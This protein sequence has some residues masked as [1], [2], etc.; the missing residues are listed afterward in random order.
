MTKWIIKNKDPILVTVIFGIF[1]EISRYLF[2][3]F[4]DFFSGI[5]ISFIDKI[6][7]LF[8]RTVSSYS[9]LAYSYSVVQFFAL[10]LLSLSIG[11]CLGPILAR[12]KDS[13]RLAK[14]MSQEEFVANIKS[15]IRKMKVVII[16]SSTVVFLFVHFFLVIPGMYYSKFDRAMTIV[17]PYVEDVEYNSLK[18][19]WFLMK[20]KAD[21]DYIDQRLL[22]IKE[23]N[24]LK[25]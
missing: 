7:D 5:G 23:K 18:S 15:S 3:Y 12:R 14:G 1:L 4:V 2:P 16:I 10:A 20:S 25:R 21:Y 22:E 19:K 17:R 13:M 8:Y 11:F 24:G 6:I 9:P